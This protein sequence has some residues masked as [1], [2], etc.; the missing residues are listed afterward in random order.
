VSSHQSSI[1]R[2]VIF[3]LSKGSCAG[4]IWSIFLGFWYGTHATTTFYTILW[5]G[6]LSRYGTVVWYDQ[7]VWFFGMV[8]AEKFVVK[9]CSQTIDTPRLLELRIPTN[10]RAGLRLF[11]P[12][13]R[14]PPPVPPSSPPA[15]LLPPRV[16]L[17]DGCSLRL[18][19]HRRLRCRP[20][21]PPPSGVAIDVHVAR[22]SS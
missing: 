15:A 20:T 16:K 18:R 8:Q 12:L 21:Q 9:V 10:R 11:R 13:P 14:T 2:L 3:F 1:L 4:Q 7:K 22:H 17:L 19:P 6:K 5:Y